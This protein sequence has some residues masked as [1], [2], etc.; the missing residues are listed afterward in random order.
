MMT[1]KDD[2]RLKW[3]L[4]LVGLMVTVSIPS[5]GYL[6]TSISDIKARMTRLETIIQYQDVEMKEVK[7]R[8]TNLEANVRFIETEMQT[9]KNK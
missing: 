8:V 7:H 9:I 2:S 3:M 1:I 4:W 6:V 5:T